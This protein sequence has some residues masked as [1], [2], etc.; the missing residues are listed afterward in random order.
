MPLTFLVRWIH[1]F[2]IL[3]AMSSTDNFQIDYDMIILSI[4]QVFF[5]NIDYD[6]YF[7]IY[8]I[9]FIIISTI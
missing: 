5:S 4:S 2:L 6:F 3:L 7:M 9:L 1:L 8:N